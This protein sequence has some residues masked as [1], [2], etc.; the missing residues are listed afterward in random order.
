MQI[1]YVPVLH[2][3]RELHELPRSRERFEKY[4]RMIVN[5]DGTDLRRVALVAANPMAKDHVRRFLDALLEFDADR[6]AAEWA[7]EV[8][9]AFD[10]LPCRASASLVVVDDLGGGWTNRFANEYGFRR[11]AHPSAKRFWLSAIL[12]SS[13]VPTIQSV[14]EAIQTAAYRMAYVTVHGPANTLGE[15]LEQES[16]VLGMAPTSGPTLDADDLEYTRE[17][18]APFLGATDMR[19]TIECLFGDEAGATLGFAPC[20]LSLWAGLALA[21]ADGIKRI[22]ERQGEAMDVLRGWRDERVK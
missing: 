13:E 19:T 17:V 18:I 2:L 11:I 8:A 12:W 5:E 10:P 3:Q 16:F 9:A 15:L 22:G 21:R 1:D 6:M 7:N 20:G 4:L 14:R